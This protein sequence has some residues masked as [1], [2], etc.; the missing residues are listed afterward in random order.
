MRL[1]TQDITKVYLQR[2]K[3]QRDNEYVRDKKKR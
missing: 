1:R 2:D 3:E